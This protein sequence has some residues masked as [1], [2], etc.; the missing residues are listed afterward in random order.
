MRASVDRVAR[1]TAPRTNDRIERRTD[2]RVARIAAEGPAAIA[3][4]LDELDREWDVERVLETNAS[5][6]ALAGF[7]LGAT[8]DRRWFLLPAVVAGFL[9]QHAVQGWCP[10]LPLLRRLGVRTRAE[11]DEERFAL[12][13][14][15]G[16]FSGVAF[17]EGDVPGV[18]RAVR[19]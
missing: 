11:I 10:P 4:R 9:F 3:R 13:A 17:D 1:N 8:V 2:E 5:S 19:R 16:D 7:A 12:K 18:L 15:R 6:L 14:L